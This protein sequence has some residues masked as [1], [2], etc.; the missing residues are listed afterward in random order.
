MARSRFA[1]ILSAIVAVHPIYG[2]ALTEAEP[3]EP[4]WGYC[5]QEYAIEAGHD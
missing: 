1:V 3:P 4:R 5:L 2:G